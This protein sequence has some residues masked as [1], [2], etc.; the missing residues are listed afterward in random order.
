MLGGFC[1][2]AR[3]SEGVPLQGPNGAAVV[4][5]EE[6]DLFGQLGVEGAVGL[7]ASDSDG[8]LA[9]VVAG[10]QG[11][12][13]M[14]AE[15]LYLIQ[16]QD[17]GEFEMAPPVGA[18][19]GV[20]ITGVEVTG[21]GEV[22]GPDGSKF[23][24]SKGDECLCLVGPE[25]ELHASALVSGS[26]GEWHPGTIEGDESFVFQTAQSEI[27]FGPDGGPVVFPAGTDQFDGG[28]Q[29]AE[30]GPEGA[31]FPV[32]EREG[33]CFHL[34][35]STEGMPMAN[36]EHA[37]VLKDGLPHQATL[38]PGDIGIRCLETFEACLA[39]GLPADQAA[40]DALNV[41]GEQLIGLGFGTAAINGILASSTQVFDQAIAEGQPPQDAFVDAGQSATQ[42]AYE[43]GHGPDLQQEAMH[44]FQDSIGIGDSP[45][46]AME[47]AMGRVQEV[48][49]AL[50]IP[51]DLVLIGISKAEESFTG[52]L[53]DGASPLEAFEAG[54]QAGEKAVEGLEVELGLTFAEDTGVESLQLMQVESDGTLSCNGE[55]FVDGAGDPSHALVN[56]DQQCIPSSFGPNESG[57]LV[58]YGQGENG[59]GPLEFDDNGTISLDAHG[60][61]VVLDATLEIP[62][63]GDSEDSGNV[64]SIDSA[65]A[66]EVSLEEESLIAEQAD[67]SS[68]EEAEQDPAAG[69]GGLG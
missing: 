58:P 53:A 32:I 24:D 49:T 39:K 28:Y 56:S 26:D 15:G 46:E 8:N 51:Q 17:S 40:G 13:L 38:P 16:N 18:T 60:D 61:P 20:H 62:V 6:Q 22:L 2:F 55:T 50:G 5:L 30:L 27:Q 12:P 21:S 37:V 33:E 14:E 44:S 45:E 64:I 69:A 29:L 52:A 41:A 31:H 65:L 9:P 11:Q 4:E 25:D 19:T 67:D 54:F 68:G 36:G 43:Q 7:L 42:Y 47:E 35:M 23:S 48:A 1:P 3:D 57:G 34:A 66:D 63:V 59:N 10:A